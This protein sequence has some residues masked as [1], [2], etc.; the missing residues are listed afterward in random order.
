MGGLHSRVDTG[1]NTSEEVLEALADKNGAFDV[2]FISD[3]IRAGGRPSIEDVADIIV[4]LVERY[5]DRL[6]AIGTDHH[7][8][9]Y[10]GPPRGLESIDKLLD[11]ER[12]LADRSLGDNSIRR[13]MGENALRI[14]YEWLG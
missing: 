9:L 10:Q 7:G 12:L 4:D 2:A 11:L 3:L 1:R 5:G 14:L 6:P 8:L 13:V